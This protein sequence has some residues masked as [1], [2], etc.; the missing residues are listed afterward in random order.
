[1]K[2]LSCC[3]LRLE[4]LAKSSKSQPNA[5]AP[6]YEPATNEYDNR[7]RWLSAVLDL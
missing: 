7:R 4:K 3:E 6:E 1:V 2:N 5:N